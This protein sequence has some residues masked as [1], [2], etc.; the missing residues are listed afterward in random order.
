MGMLTCLLYVLGGTDFHYENIIADGENPV[1]IDLETL[2][3]PST[4]TEEERLGHLSAEI[5][6]SKRLWNSV[7]RTAV[8]PRWMMGAEYA[9]YDISGLGGFDQQETLFK[10]ARW[11]H[12]NT[13]HMLVE[14]FQSKIQAEANL[15]GSGGNRL[16]PDEFVEEFVTGFTQM[17]LLLSEKR[18]ELLALEGR[19]AVFRQQRVRFVM[20]ATRI[21]TVLQHKANHPEYLRAG[22]D[23]SIAFEVPTRAKLKCVFPAFSRNRAM[24]MLLP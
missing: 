19:L 8:L 9:S 13:D 5:V 7:L 18:E 24:T 21:Y 1:L 15:P 4:P 17:Y 20:R 6:A 23:K 12:I 3:Q 22:I 14:P 10:T 2:F 11:R 16:N